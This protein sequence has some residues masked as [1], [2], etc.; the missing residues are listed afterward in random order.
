MNKEIETY[1][2]GL[3]DKAYIPKEIIRVSFNPYIKDSDLDFE[4]QTDPFMIDRNKILSSKAFRCEP[5]KTQVFTN[6]DNPYIRTRAVHTGE[7]VVNSSY[8]SSVLGLNSQLTEAQAYG[9][10]LGHG[11]FGH[12]F[13]K[14]SQNL[15]IPFRHERF[16]GIIATQIERKGDGLNLTKET[17]QGILDHS[18]GS[19]ELTPSK[20]SLNENLVVMYSDKISYIFSD[21]NDL[22]RLGWISP[23]DLETIN[24]LFPGDQRERVN[25][26]IFALIKES[27]MNGYVSFNDSKIAQSFKTIKSLLYEYYGKLNHNNLAE[28]IKIVYDCV[29]HVH[30]LQKYDPTLILALMTDNELLKLGSIA[31]C[32]RVDFDDLKT[33]GVF[34]IIENGC[35]ENKNYQDLNARLQQRLN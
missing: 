8:I 20:N 25:Q 4:G 17:L 32:K 27:A 34:E 2:N 30:Q 10:D 6:P 13:E 21:I 31:S 28:T 11:P 5:N 26:C 33:F 14:V 29:D 7:V 1:K 15:G 18:R 19:G 22:K 23:T 3:A 16:S 9:H 24:S 35:L 12:L